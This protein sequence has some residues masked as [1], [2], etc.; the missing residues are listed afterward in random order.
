MDEDKKSY[1]VQLTIAIIGLIG[2]LATAIFGNWDKLFPVD[3]PASPP[4]A[5]RDIRGEQKLAENR[6]E[7]PFE[8]TVYYFPNRK[9]HAYALSNFLTH[10]GHLVNLQPASTFPP[11][12]KERLTPTYLFFNPDEHT[13]ALALK[14][15]M[16]KNLGHVINAYRSEPPMNALS[17]R[18]VL[19]EAETGGTV[20][21]DRAEPRGEGPFQITV[22]YFPGRKDDAYDLSNFL[23]KQGHLVNLQPASTYAPLEKERFTPSYIFFEKAGFSQVMAMKAVMEKNVGHAINAY[24][25]ERT[26]NPLEMRLVLTEAEER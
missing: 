10:Q 22:Y 20:P 13:R 4:R 17:V 3:T 5:A 7:E 26:G 1:K 9:E 18:L 16:E 23:T 25:S 21:P 11:L 19:T 14:M 6:Q 24:E 15:T 2:A 12:E 8:V